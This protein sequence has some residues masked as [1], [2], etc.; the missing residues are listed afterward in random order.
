[1]IEE[2]KYNYDTYGVKDYG[3]NDLTINAD[4]KLLANLSKKLTEEKIDISWAGTARFIPGLTKD[5]LKGLGKAGCRQIDFGME[6]AS[7]SV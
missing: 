3:F 6:S 4:T 5:L 7:N 1:M 2:F